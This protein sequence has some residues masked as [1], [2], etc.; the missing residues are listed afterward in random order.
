ML[1]SLSLWVAIQIGLFFSLADE[2]IAFSGNGLDSDPVI[3]RDSPVLRTR[4]SLASLFLF[5]SL[6]LP[7]LPRLSPSSSTLP[8][9]SCSPRSGSSWRQRSASKREAF[10]SGSPA[11]NGEWIHPLEPLYDLK[12]GSSR[13]DQSYRAS[14]PDE[15]NVHYEL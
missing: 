10:K 7:V 8:A 12:A 15:T 13:A 3:G 9:A 1:L 11:S 6:S 4:S 5:L 14:H 2:I